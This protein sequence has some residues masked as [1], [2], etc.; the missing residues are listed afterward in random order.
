MRFVNETL[1]KPNL[2]SMKG[3]HIL[4]LTRATQTQLE[5]GNSKRALEFS[6]QA[7]VLLEHY[8]PDLQRAEVLLAY[9]RALAANRHKAAMPFLERTLAWLLKVANNH[10]PPE[11]RESF[12]TRNPINA[13]ILEAARTAGLELPT[14]VTLQ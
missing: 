8:E 3:L 9:H 4:A 2:K 14:S 5:L 11:Y 13:A 10:V 12:L 7:I 1:T 6:Q